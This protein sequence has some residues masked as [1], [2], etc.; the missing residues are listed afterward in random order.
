MIKTALNIN[1]RRTQKH[2]FHI[3]DPSPWPLIASMGAF[4]MLFGFTM[5]FHFYNN[6]LFLHIFGLILLVSTMAIW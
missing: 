3:V 4:F 1:A 6:G 5:Y 2:P